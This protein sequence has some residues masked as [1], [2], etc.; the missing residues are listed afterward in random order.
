V[1]RD[2]KPAR[3]GSWLRLPGGARE[4]EG[5]K[6]PSVWIALGAK[7]LGRTYQG[8]SWRVRW[9]EMTPS[10]AVENADWIGP[11][12]HPF[13]AYDVGMVI[14]TGFAAYARILHPAGKFRGSQVP[15]AASIS[16]TD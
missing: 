4:Y 6:R 11:R 5:R 14:P 9:E 2:V 16:G 3:L 1:P 8:H 13:N 15:Q 10:D 12:M 7:V